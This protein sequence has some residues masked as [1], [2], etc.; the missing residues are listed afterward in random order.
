MNHLGKEC[1]QWNVG[2]WETQEA[3]GCLDYGKW[4]TLKW[5]V[6]FPSTGA[7]IVHT[8]AEK[9]SQVSRERVCVHFSLLLAVNVLELV[10]T[11]FC[12]N[13][14]TITVCNLR[15]WNKLNLLPLVAFLTRRLI[16]A[17]RIK[18]DHHK[19]VLSHLDNRQPFLKMFSHW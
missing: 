2:L 18:T 11:I 17:P 19:C 15:L 9:A 16:T 6:P 7:W 10:A 14:L 13:I 3:A 1:C 5:V 4:S 8:R 12:L